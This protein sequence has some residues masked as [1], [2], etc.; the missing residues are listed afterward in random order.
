MSELKRWFFEYRESQIGYEE[1][2][3]QDLQA[4]ARSLGITAED[5][6]EWTRLKAEKFQVEF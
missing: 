5:E 3:L 4:T 2:D 1:V 6:A